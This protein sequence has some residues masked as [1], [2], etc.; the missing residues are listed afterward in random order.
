MRRPAAT[1]LLALACATAAGCGV[2]SDQQQVRDVTLDYLHAI[3]ARDL[4]KVCSLLTPA[5]QKH[6]GDGDA[7][8][9]PRGAASV[10]E[11]I[12]AQTR[13]TYREAQIRSIVIRGETATIQMSFGKSS[14]SAT[15]QKVAGKWRLTD[16]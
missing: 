14:S 15:L 11:A 10:E 4:K 1:I 2:R 6:V 13:E 3:G 16:G 9:C 7:A 12:D 8:R 5:A